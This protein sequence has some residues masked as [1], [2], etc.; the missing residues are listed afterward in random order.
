MLTCVSGA[1]DHA[2]GASKS[3]NLFGAKVLKKFDDLTPEQ[4]AGMSESDIAK[5]KV[6]YERHCQEHLNNVLGQ[7]YIGRRMSR[8]TIHH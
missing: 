5:A 7:N 6:F 2:S 3:M 4:L 1:T 8:N